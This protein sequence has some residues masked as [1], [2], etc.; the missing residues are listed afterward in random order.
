MCESEKILHLQAL[1]LPLDHAVSNG[2]FVPYLAAQF[3][4]SN[5][6]P[7][8]CYAVVHAFAQL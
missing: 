1:V 8:S 4:C 3:H 2:S 6:Q 7:M 5:A